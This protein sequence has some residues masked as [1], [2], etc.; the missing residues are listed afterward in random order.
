MLAR[1]YSQ[2]IMAPVQEPVR[3]VVAQP[4]PLVEEPIR[5]VVA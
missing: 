2:P 3:R 4:R 1:K 5:R